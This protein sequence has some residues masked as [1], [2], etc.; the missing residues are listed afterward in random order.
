MEEKLERRSYHEPPVLSAM[1]RYHQSPYPVGSRTQLEQPTRGVVTVNNIKPSSKSLLAT[2]SGFQSESQNLLQLLV[3]MQKHASVRRI[4]TFSAL[5][6]Q[7]IESTAAMIASKASSGTSSPP[8]DLIG[9]THAW[10]VSTSVV[11][12]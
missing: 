3:S 10:N 8:P 1:F 11:K 5:G 7:C 12:S 4:I 6:R 2:V 9:E